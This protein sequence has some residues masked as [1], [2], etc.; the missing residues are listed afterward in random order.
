MP[1]NEIRKERKARRKR[2]LFFF[3]VLILLA[4]GAMVLR[5]TVLAPKLVDVSVT[6]VHY[7]TVEDTV[8][9]T[10]A[11]TVKL[12]RRAGISP[13][14]GGRVVDLPAREGLRVQEGDLLLRLDDSVQEAQLK[15]AQSSEA[16][17]RAHAQEACVAAEEAQRELERYQDLQTRGIAS[18]QQLDQLL[19][20]RDRTEAGCLAATAGNHEAHARIQLSRTQLELCRVRAPFGGVIGAVSTEIGEWV[21]PSPPGLPMPPIIDLLDPGSAYISAPIDEMDSERIQIGQKARLSVDSR[22]GQVFPGQIVRVAPFVEDVVEQNRTVE[23][24]AEFD[25]PEVASTLLPGVSADVEIILKSREHVLEIPSLAISNSVE[26]LLFSKGRLEKRDIKV[27]LSN[28]QNS[29]VSDG[30]AEGELVVISRDSAAIQ[31]GARA[32]IKDAGH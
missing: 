29:E 5:S 13:Q 24:E 4:A 31:A 30:L 15:L 28:W 21:T 1:E 2:G 3:L 10:R 12:R 17:A 11:G 20:T 32:R 23:V 27:G 16:T 25:D 18:D 14:I 26:V 19:S 22:Q 7:G 6:P 8:T 9:N